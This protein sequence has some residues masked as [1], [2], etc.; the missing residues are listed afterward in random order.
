MN[1]TRS[2]LAALAIL[3]P[4]AAAG[5][6]QLEGRFV[7]EGR[8]EAL[9]SKNDRT[10]PGK[11]RIEPGKAYEIIAI[12]KA[13][14]DHYEIRVPGAPV[15]ERRW[16]EIGCGRHVEAGTARHVETGERMPA[17][18]PQV[19]ESRDNLLVLSWQPAFCEAQPDTRECRALN[20]RR[21][22]HAEA[23][24]SVHGL[25][26]Q[27]EGN[28]Y[29][30]VP[31]EVEELDRGGRWSGLPEPALAAET[32]AALDEAMPGAASFLDRHEWIKHGSCHRDPAG[33]EGYF[34]DTLRL[35]EEVNGSPVAD[36][37]ARNIG[38]EVETADIA[39][40]FDRAFGR[41]AG[42]RVRFLCI[43]DG[44]DNLLHEMRIALRG[45]IRP[46]TGLAELMLAARPV[47]RGCARGVVDPAGLQ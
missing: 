34:A 1:L 45:V 46:E 28:A 6:V 23:R 14:G 43:R 22:P 26:P 4:V 12:N 3:V 42:E 36:F 20:A 32:R 35:T 29:C 13:G 11:V 9:L 17:K 25:W 5:Y 16:V 15:S 31:E 41:G 21:L 39:A 40:L 30:D 44:R 24:L 7:A 37:L 8:C 38:E 27:P 33:A 19:T 10:N 18:A 47:R 2:S